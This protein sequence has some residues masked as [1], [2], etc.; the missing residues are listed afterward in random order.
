MERGNESFCVR[1][2]FEH[3]THYFQFKKKL[4][5]IQRESF[6]IKKYKFIK[7]AIRVLLHVNK[8]G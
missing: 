3:L 1:V 2:P 5:N 8:D 4:T 7:I 6:F